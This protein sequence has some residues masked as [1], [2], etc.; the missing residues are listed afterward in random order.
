MHL[1]SF[2]LPPDDLNSL[3][4]VHGSCRKPNAEGM[5]AMPTIDQIIGT[6]WKQPSGRPHFLFL[7]GDQIYADDVSIMLLYMYMD[8][9]KIYM[10]TSRQE[11]FPPET[12]QKKLKIDKEQSTSE[13]VVTNGG[14]TW[15]GTL[16]PAGKRGPLAKHFARFSDSDFDNHLISLGEYFAIYLFG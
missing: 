7:T 3:R 16:P 15:S 8:S 10:G 12:I 9:Q 11:T 2:S 14:T 5:D 6:D 4:I 1:P 13:V